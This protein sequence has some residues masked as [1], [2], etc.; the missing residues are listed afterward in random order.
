MR[1]LVVEDERRLARAIG[2]G[3]ADHGFAVELAHDG[4]TG[5]WLAREQ[6]FDA[7]VLDLMLPGLSGYEVCRRLR[8]DGNWTPILILTA[9][10]SDDAEAR[11]L[12]L[13][14]D[15]FLRKPFSYLVLIA[16]LNAL[17]RRGAPARPAKLM[18]GDLEL[19][20]ARRTVRR[21]A[22]EIELTRREFSLLE[23]LMRNAGQTR[24]KAEILD[25]VWGAD[26][27]REP[28]VVEVYVGY[29]RRKID[30]PFGTA[31]IET[32]RGHGYLLG[33]VGDG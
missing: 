30:Q 21:G 12:D 10:D 6:E 11:G 15:D 5:L 14:A 1:I 13:G 7:I 26:F 16:R 25:H 17:L 31:T 3:L 29:L 22:V 2:H 8:A 18:A 20:P 32:I 33:P 9:K 24:S 19:D 27:D 28:N 23:Y 4:D